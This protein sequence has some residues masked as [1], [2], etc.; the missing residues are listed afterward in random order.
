MLAT[1][2]NWFLIAEYDVLFFRPI[3]LDKT[4]KPVASHLAGIKISKA[5]ERALNFYHNPWLMNR[6]FARDFVLQGR[7]TVNSGVCTWNS[8]ESSPDVFFGLVCQQLEQEVQDYLWT[9]FSRNSFDIP[10]DLEK[11]RK[12]FREG[13]DIIH[14]V[15][16]EAELAFILS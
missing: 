6:Q 4:K 12:A 8:A 7:A 11:A 13:I 3:R 10:G 15:K 2:H 9:Q 1:D 14:G 16:T 5:H